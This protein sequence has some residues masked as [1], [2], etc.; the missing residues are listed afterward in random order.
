MC[1]L[2]SFKEMATTITIKRLMHFQQDAVVGLQLIFAYFS[3]DF[4]QELW[5][6]IKK[7]EDYPSGFIGFSCCF[8]KILPKAQSSAGFQFKFLLNT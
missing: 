7:M 5:K 6:D 3:R 1:K 2:E 4:Q 8:L